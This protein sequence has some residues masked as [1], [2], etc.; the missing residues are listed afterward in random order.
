TND[1]D[2][3]AREIERLRAVQGELEARLCRAEEAL[4]Q[5]RALH[6]ATIESL[7]FDFWARDSEGY[8]FSQNST[9][10]ANWGDLLGKRPEDMDTP[11]E[12][13]EVWLSN[14][15]RAL[16]GEVVSGDHDFMLR[17][18]FHSIHNVLAPIRMGEAIVGTL[19]V[20]VDVTDQKR[21]MA[22]LR[23]G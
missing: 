10:L 9:A 2:A 13:V 8:C 6:A 22:A 21:A 11:P 1:R 3:L 19:G 17:G 12:V 4:H 18:E 5:S 23:E 14:N 7:P 20:N 15:R 16:A